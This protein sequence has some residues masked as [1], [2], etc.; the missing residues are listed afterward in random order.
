MMKFLGV[1]AGGT[2][3]RA[4]VVDETG[5]CLG[6]ER[7]GGGNPTSRGLDQAVAAIVGAATAALAQSGG[8]SDD[9]SSSAVVSHAGIR[10]PEFVARLTE[11]FAELGFAGGTAF[12]GDLASTYYSGSIEPEGYALIAG[13]GTIATSVAGGRIAT[14]VGGTGWLVGDGGSGFWIGHHAARAAVAELDGLGPETALTPL[15]LE[16]IGVAEPSLKQDRNGTLQGLMNAVYADQPVALSRLAPLVFRVAD[17]A[18]ARDI[19]EGAAAEIGHLLAA[20]HDAARP[21]PLVLGGGIIAAGLAMPDSPFERALRAVAGDAE[22]T[23]VQDGAVG[24]AVL[25]LL[26]GGVALDR[27]R[28]ER[29]RDTLS[30]LRG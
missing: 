5:R 25:G 28:F 18:V 7:A 6:Y 3:T 15:V 16:A 22:F 19:L 8:P 14:V 23:Q 4:V 30:A 13:T 29:V 20:A 27:E 2:S 11:S 9:A 24:A 12:E 10:P 17:D 1:D 26:H 21:G